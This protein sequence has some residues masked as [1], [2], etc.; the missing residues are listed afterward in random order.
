MKSSTKRLLRQFNAES[1]N[2]PVNIS[3]KMLNEK[4]NSE[5]KGE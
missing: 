5:V 2:N 4:K 3:I 1:I